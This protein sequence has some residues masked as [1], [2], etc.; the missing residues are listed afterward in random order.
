MSAQKYR[1]GHRSER[2]RPRKVLLVLAGSLLI[3]SLIGGLVFSDLRRNGSQSVEGESKTVTQVIGDSV[4][5]IAID[6]PL[7]SFELPG[8]WKEIG[9][10]STPNEHSVSWQASKKGEDNRYL[11]LYVDVIPP[12][13]A[14]NRLLPVSAQGATLSYGDI[15]EK[16]ET[17][18]GNG[19]VD[20]S[21]GTQLK[22]APAKWQGVSFICNLPRMVDNQ[23][24]TGS[25]EGINQVTVTGPGKGAHRYFFLYTD[26]NIQPNYNILYEAVRSFHAK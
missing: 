2:H 21:R 3:L 20:A 25:S 26:R 19:T 13:I 8:D 24:G 10:Q 15:S 6:E 14:V 12:D 17:F 9:R 16:C 23:I 7:Y 18:T 22:P 5:R 1:Y 11:T 4:Q